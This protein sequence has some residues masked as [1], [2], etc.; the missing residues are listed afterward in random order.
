[1][2]AGFNLGVEVAQLAIVAMTLPVLW[3]L[4]RSQQYSRRLMPALS[5]ATGA[6]GRRMVREPAVARNTHRGGHGP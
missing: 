1:M 6:D 3:Q 2:L 4:S 5:V